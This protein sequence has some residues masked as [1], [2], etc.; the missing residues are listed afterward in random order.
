MVGIPQHRDPGKVGRQLVQEL[1][2]LGGEIRRH[3]G[4]AGDVAART[5]RLA[6]RPDCTGSLLT[7]MT[8]GMV[9]VADRTNGATSPPSTYIKSGLA[10]TSSRAS[11]GKRSGLLSAER[12][13]STMFWF[14]TY[15][16][17][18]RPRRNAS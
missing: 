16:S 4:D 8:M 18:R 13:S 3:E 2:T 14:S 12:G 11:R 1:Q 5:C 9:L 6:T 17:S 7:A 15:P 10:A